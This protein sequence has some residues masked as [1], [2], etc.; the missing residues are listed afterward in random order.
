LGVLAQGLPYMLYFLG[1]ERIPAQVVSVVALLEPVSGIMIGMLLY[2]EMPTVVGIA[3]I[4]LVLTSI[5]LV[6]R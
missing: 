6:S 1:L 3:G 2:R 5:V 4:F